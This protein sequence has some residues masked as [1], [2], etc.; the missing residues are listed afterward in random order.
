ML[1][2]MPSPPG[3][4]PL[5]FHEVSERIPRPET[6]EGYAARVEE[7]M[8]AMIA[9]LKKDFPG[10]KPKVALSWD[11]NKEEMTVTIKVGDHA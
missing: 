3:H 8:K 10:V 5:H 1:T 7:R 6:R 11:A 4:I 2:T 9:D